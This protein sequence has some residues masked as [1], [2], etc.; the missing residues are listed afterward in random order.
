M[1]NKEI[2]VL[3]DFEH[4]LLKPTMYV[5]SV[6]VTEEKLNVIR[7]NK[8]VS[9]IKSV[10]VGFYKLIGEILD[11]AIDEAKRQ[12]GNI[13][14]IEIHVDSKINE[15]TVVDTGGGF[16]NASTPHSKNGLTNVE[17]AVTQL[18]AGS[19]FRNDENSASVIGTNGVGAALVNML[20]E[21]FY[22]KTVND[23]EVYEQTWNKFVSTGFKTSKRKKEPTGTLVTFIPR[24]DKFKAIKIDQEYFRT[25]MIFRNYLIKND[26]LIK[27]VNF[28]VTYDGKPLDISINFIPKEHIQLETKIG[29]ILVWESFA[30]SASTSFVNGAICTGSHQYWFRELINGV[31]ESSIAHRF[32]ETFICLNFPPTLVLFGD[33]NKTRFVTTKGDVAPTLSKYFDKDLPKKVKSNKIFDRISERIVEATSEADLRKL[34]SE[35]KAKK[36]KVSDKFFPSSLE[37][38]NLFLVE[39]G[40]AAGGILQ[41][42]DPR[43]DAVYALKGKVKN[44]KKISDL[45]NN[46]EIVD[47]MNIL[48][49]DP[50]NDKNCKFKRIVIATDADAD[51]SHISSLIVNLF[52]RWF[53]NV[54]KS[55]RLFILQTP[56]VSISEGKGVKYFFNLKDFEIFA[57]T[58][59]VSSVRYL[60][61]LG[62]LNLKDW[63]SVFGEMR[64]LK[65]TE[66]TRSARM[67][68]V[69]FGNDPKLRKKWMEN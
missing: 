23:T 69:A 43:K 12:K 44:A 3:D 9:D 17:N 5:G 8:I 13:P 21:S 22:I 62:S 27:D 14:R 57:K 30:D 46:T 35:K 6:D 18:R 68:E 26:P 36:H 15:I 67:L 25:M 55:G 53:P 39:G 41:R 64:L 51:G 10:S 4:V 34:K 28:I 49:I 56:L 52:W 1:A 50:T 37:C 59:K 31:F 58:K 63:E 20:S 45:T 7:E 33:Q 42:R 40:S 61:G 2:L 48:G 11:N 60:K 38:E 47:L 54:V 16:L 29:T 32:Y 65:I 19:N 24:K 66:D